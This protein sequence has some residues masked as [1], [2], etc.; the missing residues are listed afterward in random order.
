[1][2]PGPIFRSPASEGDGAPAPIS[3]DDGGSNP[4]LRR[5]PR[6]RRR[7]ALFQKQDTRVFL[8]LICK[9]KSTPDSL[10]FIR[11]LLTTLIVSFSI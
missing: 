8:F 3:D 10:V 2:M 7:I 6:G 5:A 1:M 9:V 4:D 11:E